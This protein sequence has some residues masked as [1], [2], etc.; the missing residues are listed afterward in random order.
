MA[1]LQRVE[2]TRNGHVAG[3][4]VAAARGPVG[5]SA[6]VDLR[7][8]L[9]KLLVEGEPVL[10]DVSGLRLDWTP[11]AEVFVAAVSAAGGW[12][13]ARLVLFGADPH[14]AE[15]LRACRVTESVPLAASVD[16]AAAR[17]GDRPTRLTCGMELPAEP[18]SVARARDFLRDV[19]R[20]WGVPDRDDAVTVVTELVTNAVEHA[21]T[22]LRLR[23]VLDRAG[24][25]VSVRDG[26]PG[27]PDPRGPYGRGLGTVV[28][29]SR[30]WGV[31]HY[32]DGKAVWAQLPL[33]PPARRPV[34]VLD[35][36]RTPGV[37]RTPGPGTPDTVVTAARRRRFTTVD[38]EH[39]HAFL[40][41]VYGEHTLRL[42][43]ADDL[44]GFPLEYDGVTTNRFAVE[45]VSH[46]A[47]FE[48]R[49]APAEGLV[50]VH[51]LDG[52]LHVE[53]RH[54]ELRAAPGDLV[55]CD[56]GADTVIAASRLDVEVVR[57]E[58]PAVARVIAELTGYDAP[59]V[60]F[61]L[62]RPVS[63][64]RAAHWRASVAHLRR[65]VLGNDEVMA[66]PLA[67]STVF[68]TLVAMLVETFPNPARTLLTGG[69]ADRGRPAPRALRRALQFVEEHAG[70]DIGLAD[71]AAT[72][73][74]G[75]R[76]LQ[77]VFRRYLDVTPLEHLRRVR[78]ERAHRDLQALN[79]AEVTVGAI[80]DRWGFPH[81]GNFSALYLRT[82]G[83]SPSITLRS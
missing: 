62:T 19:S 67:R 15:R 16:D 47:S 29:L 27:E 79:P 31:L 78:L 1:D 41:S 37:R 30:T 26:H 24:L 45:H 82:Y 2:L 72:A 54:A 9:V 66:S 81:H 73:G 14:L 49:F 10:L 43:A 12:P 36:P 25:R 6:A 11:A 60:P 8:G 55:L 50:V 42:A 33:T 20:R 65:D 57:L 53:S 64:A 68:R 22:P 44:A 7:H 56:T 34:E 21:G 74:I 75:T 38:P 63:A 35:R 3:A 52:D 83:R 13:A 40:R 23:L 4:A 17:V 61:G 59:T 51:P 80:A 39:A 71:I 18:A 58:S 5:P 28:G 70:D 46:P 69:A 48:A 76:G 77:L 32:R